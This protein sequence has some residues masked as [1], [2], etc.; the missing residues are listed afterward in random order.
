MLP[1]KTP[2][3]SNGYRALLKN[4]P[5]VLLW[6]GQI[7]SQIADKVLVVLAISLLEIYGIPQSWNLS[8]SSAVF[9][10]Q[11]IPA[12]I[13][14]AAAGTFVDRFPKKPIMVLSDIVRAFLLVSLIFLPKQFVFLLLIVFAIS[15]VTQVFAPAEQSALPLIVKSE[16][17]ITA[18]A[19][20][21][22]TNMGSVIVGFG[23]GPIIIGWLDTFVKDRGKIVFV[24]ILYLLAAS[25]GQFVKLSESIPY[26][27]RRS[28]RPWS[29]FAEGLKYLK[30]K[31]ILQNAIFQQTI[32]YSVIAALQLLA[33]GLTKPLGLQEKEFGFLVAATGVGLLIGAGALGH[34]GD[35]L[36]KK[37]LSLIGFISIALVLLI[38]T[39]VSSVPLALL[40]SVI[41]GCG[42]ACIAVPMQTL[43]QEKTPPDMRG[44]VFGFQNN[45][46]NI[47]LSLPQLLTGL[48]VLKFG[49]NAVLIGLS[50]LVVIGGLWSRSA[51]L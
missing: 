35:R 8:S 4:R 1:S 38:F 29:D 39:V 43:I 3:E 5:F 19:I 15:T 46:H 17:L 28:V 10:M 44:K 18:N 33:I 50:L 26:K 45:A 37:P 42:A 22:M 7:F 25:I 16:N 30:S 12:I 41:L 20:F 6:L 47:A 2:I 21:V 40:F 24:A 14:G 48:L 34:W 36:Q 49:L 31:P 27:E 32:L 23:I 9:I 51:S 11:T 13:F